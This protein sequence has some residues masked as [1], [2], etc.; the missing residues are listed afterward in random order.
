M[1]EATPSIARP[2]TPIGYPKLAEHIGNHSDLASFRSFAGLN[3]RNILYLQAEL[4]ELESAIK[5]VEERDQKRWLDGTG[6]NYAG[7]WFWLGGGGKDD[8]SKDQLD[9]VIRLR[10]L[11]SQYSQS[12][13]YNNKV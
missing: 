8:K 4:L 2:I 10:K 11:L 9:L 6:E 5:E 12:L 1:A 3:A 7:T 13:F